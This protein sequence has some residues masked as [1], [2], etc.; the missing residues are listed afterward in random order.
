MDLEI[1]IWSEHIEGH[2]TVPY[3]PG[4][5]FNC[6][7]VFQTHFPFLKLLHLVKPR[8]K[9][10]L[11]SIS[12]RLDFQPCFPAHHSAAVKRRQDL[13]PQFPSMR[14]ILMA[15]MMPV[16]GLYFVLIM[17][18][19]RTLCSNIFEQMVKFYLSW[20]NWFCFGFHTNVL[21]DWK[22]PSIETMLESYQRELI[23][24]SCRFDIGNSHLKVFKVNVIV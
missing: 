16:P 10:N 19:K 2:Q 1:E 24:L 3:Q 6:L 5:L 11:I 14:S 13:R 7:V 9:D 12:D 18:S 21:C 23:L 4:A 22:Q 8:L 17:S 20:H 15:A